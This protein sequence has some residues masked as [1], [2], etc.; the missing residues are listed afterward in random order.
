MR[1]FLALVFM[2]CLAVPAGI[3]ISGCTRNPAGNYCYGLGYGLKNT[4]VAQITL[5]PQTTG[6]SLAY[7]QTQQLLAPVATS[8]IGDVVSVPSS[9]FA[10]GTS[11]NKLVDISPSGN[12]CAGTWNR[13]TGGGIA[14]YIYCNPPSPAPVTN[15]LPYAVA[16]ITASANSAT[17]NPVAVYI[18]AQV[19]SISLVGPQQCTSQTQT[20]S[21]DSQACYASGGKQYLLCKPATITDP[22]QF[23]CPLPSGVNASAI[24]ACS[25]AIG[26]LSYT[27]GNDSIGNI[28]SATN[29]ITA[30]QP[31]TTV[32]TATVAGSAASAGY[33]TTCP[34]QSISLTLADGTTKGTITQGVQQTLVTKTLDTNGMQLT[35]I[36]L[37]YQSTNPIDINM[38]STGVVNTRYPGVASVYA[39]CQPPT[40]NTSPIN[41]LGFN[42][43]GLSLTSNAVNITT[44]GTISD[45]VWFAAP[46]LSQYFV[47][48][49]LLTGTVG[50]AVRMPYVPNSMMMDK[51]GTNLYF[52]SERELMV[53]NTSSNSLSKQDPSV[54][55][56]VLAVSPDNTHIL[57]NDQI[58][59]LFYIY[60]TTTGS[61]ISFPGVANAA[62]WSPDSKTLY[63]TDNASLN[64]ASVSGHSD[65]LYVYNA[66]TGWSTY[67]LPPSPLPAG[68]VPPATLDGSPVPSNVAVSLTMQTPA[69]TVPGVGAYLRGTPTSART[70]CPAGTVGNTSN[71]TLYSIGDSVPVQSD[72]LAATT[73]GGH[74]LGA[75]LS[76]NA[77]GP[78]A[79]SDIS[80][81]IPTTPCP[82]ASTGTGSAQV[83]TLSPLTIQHPAAYTASTLAV[84]AAAVNQI[85]A[86]PV[87]NLAFVTYS[88]N[89]TANAPLPY[90]IPGVNGAQG[91]VGY[92]TLTGAANITAPVAG[93]F[94]PD[95]SIFFVST[96]GDNMIHY[97]AIPAN[98]AATAPTDTQQISPNLPACTPPGAGGLDPGCTYSGAGTIVPATTI[99][100]TPRSTT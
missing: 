81:T 67:P 91:T 59:Q 87:S 62:A 99:L 75:S 17:S 25:S 10:Y 32:I 100:V 61:S 8:C 68:S 71:M 55:G 41:E 2:M 38:N 19:S 7:G 72:V 20:A 57:I 33:F 51:G 24:P 27:A 78:I 16:Y 37:D 88:G 80:V 6:I 12:L 43:T 70:W 15:G 86:S 46:G 74:I 97:I 79:L 48:I 66:N 56:V 90:Y 13:N 26:F 5:Q 4:D 98:P 52:G 34:P 11:N 50:S 28:N 69:L 84:N 64:T 58:R 30:V 89:G 95:D 60:T 22:A 40:C 18:H 31:G 65:T 9:T 73:D 96:A 1:R 42:Q 93:A 21:L 77:A 83:Q 23:A 76:G 14:D 45:Y 82:F 44:P 53:Y 39:V 63:I 47:P 94:T 3:S 54:P 36:N 92:V 49:E 29:V 85:V 35:G